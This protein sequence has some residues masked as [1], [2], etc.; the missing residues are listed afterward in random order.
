MSLGRVEERVRLGAHQTLPATDAAGTYSLGFGYRFFGL[1]D[2][3]FGEFWVFL[4]VF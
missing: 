3:F 4:K 1:F 2:V